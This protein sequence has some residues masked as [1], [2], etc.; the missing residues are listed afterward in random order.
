MQLT[1]AEQAK[2][3]FDLVRALSHINQIYFMFCYEI[4]YGYVPCKWTRFD[5][6]YKQVT[7]QNE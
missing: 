4:M 1:K 2:Q 3:A 5:M 7:K 6:A